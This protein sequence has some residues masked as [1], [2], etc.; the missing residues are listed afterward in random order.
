MNHYSAL[1]DRDSRVG[2]VVGREE[3]PPLFDSE[4]FEGSS[5]TESRDND[6]AIIGKLLSTNHHH[7]VM[8]NA[9]IPHAI[10]GHSKREKPR[11]V[12][13]VGR[14]WNPAEVNLF[15]AYWRAGC[16]LA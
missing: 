1:S 5:A 15:D 16:H 7:I 9:A 6:V 13:P 10:P 2:R 8:E 12:S 11:C 4:V 14:C 3:R